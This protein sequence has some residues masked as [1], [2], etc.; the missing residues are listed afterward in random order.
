MLMLAATGS[1]SAQSA[2]AVETRADFIYRLDMQIGIKPVYPAVPSFKDVPISNPYYGYIEAAAQMGIANGFSNGTF[3]PTLALTRAE[4]AKYEVIAYGKG[5]EA[6]A[7]TKTSF[8]DNGT[9]PVAL[10]GY[11]A[12]ANLLGLLNGFANGTFQPQAELSVAQERHLLAQLASAMAA[13][14][15]AYSVKVT[16]SPMNVSPGQF[17]TLAARVT[18]SSGAAVNVPVTFA[19]T[20]GN[21]SNAILSGSS[22]VAS[23]P[24]VYTITATAGNSTGTA[25]VDVYGAA[26]GLKMTAPSSV[27]ANGSAAS[28]VTVSFVDSSG[29]V[30][31]NDNSSVTLQT[32]NVSAVAVVSGSVAGGSATAT[33]ID[34]IA[35]F[36]VE[37]GSLPGATATVT[38]SSGT[39]TAATT[40]TTTA[41]TAKS[42][43]VTPVSPYLAVNA[44]GATQ[45]LMVKVLDQS[46]QPMIYG[47]YTFTVSISGPATFPGGGTSPE[48]FVYSGV[49]LNSAGTPVTIQDVQGSTGT[50][51]VTASATG[52]TSGT[53]TVTAVVAGSPTAI[54]VTAPSSASFSADSAGVGLQ[55]SIAIVDSHGYPVESAHSVVITVKNSAGQ[56]ATNMHVDGFTQTST[57]GATD[58]NAVTNGHFTVTDNGGG[59]D[60]GTYT[61]QATDPDGVLSPSADITFTETAGVAKVIQL[62][63]PQFISAASPTATYTGQVTDA[64]GNPVA[65]S[66]VPVTFTSTASSIT[67]ATQTVPTNGSGQAQATFTV[68]GYVGTSYPVTATATLNGQTYTTN[69]VSFTVESTTAQAVSVSMADNSSGTYYGNPAMAQSG[70]QVKVTIKATDQYGNVVQTADKVVLS[71]SGTGTLTNWSTAVLGGGG[72]GNVSANANGTYTVTLFG[73]QAVL[74]ATAGTTGEVSLQA[75]DESVVPEASGSAAMGIQAGQVAGFGIFD[76]AGNH[77]TSESVS[78]NTPSTFTLKAVDVSGNAAIPTMNF[79][80]LPQS[81]QAGGQFRAG[82]PSGANLGATQGVLVSPGSGGVELYYVTG[83]SQ[84]GVALTAPYWVGYPSGIGQNSTGAL[85]VQNGG[86]ITFST[87]SSG[88]IADLTTSG[89]VSGTTFTAPTS[90]SSTDTLALEVGG[91]AVLTF[92]VSW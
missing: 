17:V 55:F 39:F 22:F 16:A 76:S 86:T 31:S 58:P 73:G 47:T 60:A 82:S 88:S 27:V 28:T 54:Q 7:I 42:V 62:T 57:A 68:P 84:T 38:A 89:N 44:P 14:K 91:N 92:Q 87:N 45:T 81:S 15:T 69:P 4:A 35:T 64:Y 56:I 49:G 48:S 2:V 51:T 61:L 59:A 66:G 13:G 85:V 36:T 29:N 70:D 52:L 80:V 34:G 9:I 74:A 53:G 8:V 79:L 11:V 26:V 72:V 90:G 21:A 67:P 83:T 18:D 30:V 3:G 1:A 25:S 77:A 37:G 43:S 12:E 46:G 75:T 33:A 65:L 40:V 20:S 23:Q 41:Q 24:G 78:A 5:S 71:T 50:I 63:A 19:V 6:Q 10:V 32:S